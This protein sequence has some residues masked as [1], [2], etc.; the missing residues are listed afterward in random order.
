[1]NKLI[2][3]GKCI[4]VPV[5]LCASQTK[6]STTSDNIQIENKSE[7]TNEISGCLHRRGHA[8]Q[9]NVVQLSSGGCHERGNVEEKARVRPLSRRILDGLHA[10][11]HG[12]K[13]RRGGAEW[14]GRKQC[15]PNQRSGV[16]GR[17]TN[18]R[19]KSSGRY[20]DGCSCRRRSAGH[21]AVV[22]PRLWDSCVVASYPRNI[23]NLILDVSRIKRPDASK[24]TL[25]TCWS[26]LYFEAHNYRKRNSNLHSKSSVLKAGRMFSVPTFNSKRTQCRARTLLYWSIF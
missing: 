16:R 10:R 15:V 24:L 9:P 25:L 1:M 7:T 18:S 26:V 22:R 6:Q 13:E 20:Y 4:A 17:R 3:N 11:P 8:F 21:G 5:C 23:R 14:P 19:R 12:R 2:G